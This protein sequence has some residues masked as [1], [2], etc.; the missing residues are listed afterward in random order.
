MSKA[1]MAPP[2]APCGASHTGIRQHGYDAAAHMEQ[3]Y[4]LCQVCSTT[5]VFGWR[6]TRDERR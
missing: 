4:L 3:V 1:K 5:A 6:L 2:W